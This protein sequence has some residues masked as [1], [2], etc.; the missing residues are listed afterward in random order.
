MANLGDRAFDIIFQTE[1]F[2]WTT[3]KVNNECNL[4]AGREH[5]GHFVHA[6]LNIKVQGEEYIV[7]NTHFRAPMRRCS[8]INRSSDPPWSGCATEAAF[9]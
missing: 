7:G 6:L 5:A 1:A 9:R 4:R 2:L 8:S 3:G